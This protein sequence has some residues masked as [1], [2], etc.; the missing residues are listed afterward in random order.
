MKIGVDAGALGIT[1]ERLKL[2]VYWVNLNLLRELAKRDRVNTYYLYTFSP[3]DKQVMAS[4]GPR[5]IN[6]ILRPRF[7]W[8]RL[9]LP[10][11][12]FFRR[13]DIF[14]G[15]SQAM[16][17]VRGKKIGVVY[18]LGFI[19][20]PDSYQDSADRLTDQTIDLV[21]KSDKL[22]TISETV[23]KDI[24]AYY[25][26]D[27]E[28]VT[29]AYPGVNSSFTPYGSAHKG[30]HPYF[31]FVGALKAGKNVPSILAGFAQFLKTQKKS[32]SMYLIGGEYWMDPEID[33]QIKK[34]GIADNVHKLGFVSET[35]LAEYYRGAVGFISPSWHEGFCLPAVEAMACGCP[36]IVSNASV[37][38]EIVGENGLLVH[39]DEPDAIAT[40]METLMHPATRANY[41]SRGIARAKIFTWDAFGKKIFDL[42]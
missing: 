20:Y 29:V 9:R 39:P 35:Q 2:G 42:L 27:P 38:P 17:R 11:E 37:F 7:G 1:D 10:L 15:L 3:I 12:L 4:L 40:A 32:Y 41:V 24:V 22:I 16:P 36:V 18:D 33:A 8:F 26:V 28:K 5:M 6:R 13:V 31:V 34:L 23:K 19:H 14:L 30:K 25:G 21:R